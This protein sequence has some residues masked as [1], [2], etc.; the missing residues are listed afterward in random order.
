MTLVQSTTSRKITTSSL[1]LPLLT[2]LASS[3]TAQESSVA[4]EASDLTKTVAHARQVEGYAFVLRAEATQPILAQLTRGKSANDG[5]SAAG[6][7]SGSSGAGDEGKTAQRKQLFSYQVRQASGQH[8]LWQADGLDLVRAK[9]RQ[10]L[11]YSSATGQEAKK[12]GEPSATWVLLDTQGRPLDAAKD[13]GAKPAPLPGEAYLAAV[14]PLPHELL[15]TAARVEAAAGAAGRR[16][17]SSKAEP[18]TFV[19]DLPDDARPT[20]L[21]KG[22]PCRLAIMTD[23]KGQLSAVKL[24]VRPAPV[25]RGTVEASGKR[26]AGDAAGRSENEAAPVLSLR[27]RITKYGPQEIKVPQGA[28]TLL[29]SL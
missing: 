23:D 21:P 27:Y 16:S 26:Q 13:A 5:A 29:G 2:L 17:A 22:M 1:L 25:E 14:S 6:S 3:A 28:R 8:S 20:W 10:A 7:G 18:G 15:L 11:K 24:D 4:R 9:K 12:A 19:C